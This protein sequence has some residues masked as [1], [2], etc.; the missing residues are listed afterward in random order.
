MC[1]FLYETP[2]VQI[3]EKKIKKIAILFVLLFYIGLL[4]AQVNT[5]AMR[6]AESDG[7]VHQ[8]GLD[9]AMEKA[10]AEVVD[11]AA[12][13]RM[14]FSV[15]KGLTSFL[16]L[17]Y[18]NGYEKEKSSEK[19]ISVNKGFAHLRM[20]K[21]LTEK[22]FIEGFTQYGFNDFLDLENRFLVGTGLRIKLNGNDRM[23]TFLGVGAMQENE[24]YGLQ[25]EPEKKLL[26]STNYLKHTWNISENVQI[27]NTVYFQASA[28]DTKDYRVL[29]DGGL[30]IAVGESLS[31]SMEVN[32]RYDNFPHGN[33]GNTYLQLANGI[34]FVF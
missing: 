7:I 16:I 22:Y 1:N 26:R 4:P 33:L 17:N 9:L 28:S 20:T 32:Y 31:I 18:E 13:Y 11:I 25:T 8:F 23:T 24:K 14:D 29:Y 2:L 3:K 21:S 6:A 5:E 15:I 10:D 27:N 30:D 12:E 34:T 19:N